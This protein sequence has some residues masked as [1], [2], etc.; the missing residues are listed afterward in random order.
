M[1]GH[2]GCKGGTPLSSEQGEGGGTQVVQG[3]TRDTG[4]QRVHGGLKSCPG[5]F[6]PA[7]FFFL[8]GGGDVAG[9]ILV[10]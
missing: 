8:V 4:A 1:N 9:R 2:V 6:G 5:T 7:F 10:P 3:Y